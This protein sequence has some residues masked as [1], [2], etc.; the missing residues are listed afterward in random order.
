M[1]NPYIFVNIA[2]ELKS[3]FISPDRGIEKGQSTQYAV[4]LPE[5]DRP[6]NAGEMHFTHSGRKAGSTH[7]SVM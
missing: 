2:D 6:T 1:I 5:I 3:I 7:Y 4:L